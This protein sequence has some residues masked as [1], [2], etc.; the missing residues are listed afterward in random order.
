MPYKDNRMGNY[1]LALLFVKS[2]TARLMANCGKDEVMKITCVAIIYQI[3]KIFF[4]L[5][6]IELLMD[7]I[8]IYDLMKVGI[9]MY[10]LILYNPVT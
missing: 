5:K 6:N 7:M 3:A 9:L 4:C 2:S 10:N 8:F 1:S